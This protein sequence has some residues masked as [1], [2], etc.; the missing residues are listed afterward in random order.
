MVD[1]TNLKQQLNGI[2]TKAQRLIGMRS[3]LQKEEKKFK[4]EINELKNEIIIREK[5]SELLKNLLDNLINENVNLISSLVTDG[6]KLV[7]EDQNISFRAEI[8]QK[9]DLW[10]KFITTHDDIEGDVLE[11]FGGMLACLESFILRIICILKLKLRRVLIL[12]EVFAQVSSEYL[13]NTSRLIK[14][15]C[16]QFNIDLL[17][18]THQ[19][20][21]LKYADNIY[22]AS[23]NVEQGEKQ[24]ILVKEE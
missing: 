16:D 13:E 15:L 18:V 10:I 19:K 2:N 12:D 9:K 7:V 24:L 20:K 6:L 11:S 1:L 3:Q 5:T 22:H 4:V 21:L 14:K 17:L 8:Q 23:V